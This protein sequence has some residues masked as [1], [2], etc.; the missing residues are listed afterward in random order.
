M[1]WKKGKAGVQSMCRVAGKV[2]SHSYERFSYVRKGQMVVASDGVCANR[3]NGRMCCHVES[4]SCDV[5]LDTFLRGASM[6]SRPVTFLQLG[7]RAE[8]GLRAEGITSFGAP[9]PESVKDHPSPEASKKTAPRETGKESFV[10]GAPTI[11]RAKSPA[12]ETAET[13]LFGKRR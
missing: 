4:Q 9:P 12:R 10:R 3:D 5:R 1:E 8:E 7:Q 2:V 13:V 11:N 6:S